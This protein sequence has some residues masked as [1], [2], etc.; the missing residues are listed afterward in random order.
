M[1][2]LTAAV[3]VLAGFA[4]G[5]E[6][7][8][9]V[10]GHRIG[11][12]FNDYLTVAK[13]STENAARALTDC[14]TLVSDRKNQKRYLSGPPTFHLDEWFGFQ[15]EFDGCLQLAKAVEGQKALI[16]DGL[17][18]FMFVARKLVMIR[19]TILEDFGKVKGDLTQKYGPPDREEQ[20]RYQN[21]FGAVYLHPR[22]TWERRA[23]VTI[24]AEED[25]HP[26]AEGVPGI[27][28]IYPITVDIADWTW[29]QSLVTEEENRP[30]SIE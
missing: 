26:V 12:T 27:R 20:V 22:V 21:G 23:D 10:K 17:N 28:K 4:S 18:G 30:S 16:Q 24:R 11:E 3:L 8:P 2:A 6:S 5:Q 25:A 14:G 7:S 15:T 29:A 1:R 9:L 13:G 19:L